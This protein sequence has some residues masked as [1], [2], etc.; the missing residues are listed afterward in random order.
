MLRHPGVASNTVPDVR[1]RH[2]RAQQSRGSHPSQEFPV[3]DVVYVIVTIALFAVVAL[4][5]KGVEK[6]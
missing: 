6:L 1:R 2:A 3:L 5:A 4:V